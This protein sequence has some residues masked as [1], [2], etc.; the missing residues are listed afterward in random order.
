MSS[1]DRVQSPFHEGEQCRP[2]AP[3]CTRGDRALGPQGRA[4]AS[5]PTSSGPSSPS[6]PSWWLLRETSRGAP[7]PRSWPGAPASSRRPIHGPWSSIPASYPAMHW[8]MRC[9]RV[10]TWAC[11]ASSSRRGGATGRTARF[12]ETLT[13]ASGSISTRA[14]AIARS[15]S[16]SGPG[17][18]RQSPP[19]AR[20]HPRSRSGSTPHLASARSARPTPSS[21]R[22]ATAAKAKTGPSAWTRRTAAARRASST[23]KTTA[24]S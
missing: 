9:G 3:R 2:A 15:T 11:S 14:S 17:S 5:C 7:G 18:R 8:R 20:R 12:A 24:P 21:S 4:A 13:T 19:I 16:R 22:P 23:S 1:H 10:P 6:C